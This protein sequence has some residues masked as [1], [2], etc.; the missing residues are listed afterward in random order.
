MKHE[1]VGIWVD[2]HRAMMVRLQDSGEPKLIEIHADEVEHDHRKSTSAFHSKRTDKGAWYRGLFQNNEKK[3]RIRERQKF[4]EEIGI[5]LQEADNVWVFGPDDTRQE[6]LNYLINDGLIRINYDPTEAF[7]VR[8]NKA[9][10]VDRVRE[11]FTLPNPRTF[12]VGAGVP[13]REL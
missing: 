2:H 3:R 13:G 5:Q 6:L 11:H 10:I 12:H 7:T 9:Q 1:H 8:A 4:Y